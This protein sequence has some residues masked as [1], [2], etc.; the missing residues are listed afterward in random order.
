[1]YVLGDSVELPDGPRI[2]QSR[3]LETWALEAMESGEPVRA[4]AC[5]RCAPREPSGQP[6]RC[7]CDSPIDLSEWNV[8]AVI[9][10]NNCYSFARRARWCA[11][12]QGSQ[13]GDQLS[14]NETQIREGLFRDGLVRVTEQDVLTGTGDFV[15]LLLEG[16]H[17]YHFLRLDGD[18]WTHMPANH[19]AIACDAD[20]NPILK[21]RLRQA[22]MQGL[23][24]LDYFRVPPNTPLTH[25][26]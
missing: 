22:N 15:A 4:A 8:A 12:G 7:P 9:N 5:R 6:L 17:N 3:N 26:F 11:G 2:D 18:R 20:G 21:N 19:A 16:I 24:F 23:R 25:C 14:S 13:P 10:H 1:M